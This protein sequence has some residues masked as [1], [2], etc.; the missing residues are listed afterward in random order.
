MS[1]YHEKNFSA[2]REVSPI[3]SN[4]T[5]SV[6]VYLIVVILIFGVLGATMVSLFTTATTSSAT[7]NDARRACMMAE[8]AIRYAFSQLRDNDFAEGTINDLNSTTYN[9]TDAGSFSIRAFSLWFQ[10]SSTQSSNPYT[11][12]IPKGRLPLDFIVPVNRNVWIINFKYLE[13]TDD[14]RTRSPISTYTRVDDTTAIFNLSGNL[15]VSTDEKVCLGVMPTTTQGPLNAGADLYVEQIAKD[16]FP[17]FNG[18]ININRFDYSYERLVDEPANNRVRL[19]NLTASNFNNPPGDFPLTVTK[20]TGGIYTGDF[21]VLSPRNYMVVPTGLSETASCGN[22][23]K[24][25]MNIFNPSEIFQE[26]KD[27]DIPP[28]IFADS[29][30]PVVTNPNMV[31]PI[32]DDDALDIGGNHSPGSDAVP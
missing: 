17:R 8:S 20:T 30:N 15:N 29:I 10:S 12:T 19:E 9:V 27:A 1:K 6:L 24:S 16:F 14:T 4:Q 22:E 3:H 21:I 7:P 23:Y 25:G 5:G 28:D 13:N 26:D 11:F 2:F 31:T 32:P 18:V